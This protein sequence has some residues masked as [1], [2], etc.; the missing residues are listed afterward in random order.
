MYSEGGPFVVV[1]ASRTAKRSLIPDV[2]VAAD[3]SQEMPARRA[4]MADGSWFVPYRCSPLT[5]TLGL[6]SGSA[7]LIFS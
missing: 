4:P 7:H 3:L 6:G 1:P 5:V 2:G